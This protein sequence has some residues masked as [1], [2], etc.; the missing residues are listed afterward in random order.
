MSPRLENTGHGLGTYQ[1]EN[2]DEHL[3]FET[4]R[5]PSNKN[6]TYGDYMLMSL[7]QNKRQI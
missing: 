6:M 7:D 4:E 5:R 3:D 2:M 1:K